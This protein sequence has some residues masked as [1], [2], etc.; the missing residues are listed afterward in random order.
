MRLLLVL[1][2]KSDLFIA[3]PGYCFPAPNYPLRFIVSHNSLTE[4]IISTHDLGQTLSL[5]PFQCR[6]RYDPSTTML[7][8]KRKNK[9]PAPPGDIFFLPSPKSY[10]LPTTAFISFFLLAGLNNH[11]WQGS[12]YP[13][14]GWIL[15]VGIPRHFAS[16]LRPFMTLQ[17]TINT[18]QK[19]DF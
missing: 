13:H 10:R 17:K 4:P 2:Y 16:L 15:L 11:Y 3:S 18:V 8:D 6:S 1:P 9:L 14:N 5:R 19:P 12:W 7:L